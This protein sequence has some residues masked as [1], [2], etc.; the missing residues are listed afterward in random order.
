ML[1]NAKT[2]MKEKD[3]INDLSCLPFAYQA[4]TMKG[5]KEA[6]DLYK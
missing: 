5:I 4:E 1:G 6:L 2:D 3:K